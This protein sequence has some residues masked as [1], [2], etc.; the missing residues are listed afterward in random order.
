MFLAFADLIGG[1]GESKPAKFSGGFDLKLLLR[2]KSQVIKRFWDDTHICM[3]ANTYN[4]VD[5][6]SFILN[7]HVI[8]HTSFIGQE[9]YFFSGFP[10]G[11]TQVFKA[12]SKFRDI[13]WSD[14]CSFER[15]AF[16][17]LILHNTG[18]HETPTEWNIARAVASHHLGFFTV[19]VDKTMSRLSTVTQISATRFLQLL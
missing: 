8:L 9:L 15:R 17:V 18:G 2:C 7:E 13:S 12:R 10:T 4:K 3:C 6:V 19:K 14:E 5:S 11:V 16:F 1:G